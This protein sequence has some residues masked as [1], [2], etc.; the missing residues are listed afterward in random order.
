MAFGLTPHFS[1][2]CGSTCAFFN[3]SFQPFLNV[4]FTLP[5]PRAVRPPSATIPGGIPVLP[6]PVCPVH[7]KA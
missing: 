5:L 4:I 2:A 7:R 3:P 6:Y 1:Q